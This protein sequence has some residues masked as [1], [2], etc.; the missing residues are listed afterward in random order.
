MKINNETIISAI[1]KLGDSYE[2][3]DEEGGICFLNSLKTKLE[4]HID[5]HL[6]QT[7]EKTKREEKMSFKKQ[8]ISVFSGISTK[9]KF[10]SLPLIPKI[11]ILSLVALIIGTG[12][13]AVASQSSL[14]GDTLYPIKILG[15]NVRF[16]L[17]FSSEA[18]MKLR[19]NLA[20]E[21]IAEI[22][23]MLKGRGVEP[24][25]LETA[26]SRLEENA[27]GSIEMIYEKKERGEDINELKESVSND[28]EGQRERLRLTIEEY[29]KNS[30]ENE[31]RLKLFIK[32]NQREINIFALDDLMDDSLEETAP[33]PDNESL[34]GENDEEKD[35]SEDENDNDGENQNCEQNE[36]RGDE[37]N[38]QLEGEEVG[39]QET[40]CEREENR[41][42]NQNEENNLEEQNQEQNQNQN[43][44]GDPEETDGK[45]QE[46]SD[47]EE[48]SPEPTSVP[49]PQQEQEQDMEN[50]NAETGTVE[51]ASTSVAPIPTSAPAHTLARTPAHTRG[52]GKQ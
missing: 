6:V 50:E 36:N 30:E 39:N 1:K 34:D 20:D 35:N 3:K 22:E 52:N 47:L 41:E 18:K 48:N 4:A 24:K 9:R 21:R 13:A 2:E 31:T 26:L 51:G 44:N 19:N 38:G 37:N 43:N 16:A 45:S 10:G 8:L 29:T 17:T 5:D 12:G 7:A 49:E 28:I 33:E 15:E 11:A 14:P 27:K 32:N 25:G 40:V 23:R 46:E 42:K